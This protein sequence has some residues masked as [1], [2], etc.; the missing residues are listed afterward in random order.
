MAAFALNDI[1][2]LQ[3]PGSS[4]K[5]DSKLYAG[6]DSQ[7]AEALSMALARHFPGIPCGGQ[8]RGAP[9]RHRSSACA[10]N[11]RCGCHHP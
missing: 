3:V 10:G 11:R 2:G 4:G 1:G 6:D 9:A 7:W 5:G 8:A